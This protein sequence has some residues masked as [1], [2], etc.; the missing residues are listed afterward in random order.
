M[1]RGPGRVQRFVLGRVQ[2][3]EVGMT[4]RRQY[5]SGFYVDVDVWHGA[6][7]HVTDVAANWRHEGVCDE[8]DHDSCL[9][10]YKI[11]RSDLETVRRAVKALERVGTIETRYATVTVPVHWPTPYRKRRYADDREQ[12]DGSRRSLQFRRA[13]SVDE[14]RN[15]AAAQRLLAERGRLALAEVMSRLA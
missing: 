8:S 2:H 4:T 3:D 6:W 12:G 13:L 11:T 1:S 7:H 9:V 14:R 5:Q 10:D 15:E